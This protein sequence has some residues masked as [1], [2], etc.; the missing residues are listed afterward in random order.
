M[1][2]LS[3]VSLV[4]LAAIASLS[5]APVPADAA[6]KKKPRKTTAVVAGKTIRVGGYSYKYVDAIVEFRDRTFLRDPHLGTQDG[7]FDSGYFFD[8]NVTP[9]GSDAPYLN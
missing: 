4:G 2:K 8:S 9:F 1:R 5:L 3:L 6:G 7:P